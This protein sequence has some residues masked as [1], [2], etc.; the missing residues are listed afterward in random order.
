MNREFKTPP[1]SLFSTL[2]NILIDI[3]KHVHSINMNT[4]FGE[5][6]VP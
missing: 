2:K 1:L 5:S 3:G 4:F 6:G